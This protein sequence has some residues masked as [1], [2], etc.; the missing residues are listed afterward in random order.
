MFSIELP[1]HKLG[2]LVV[3]EIIAPKGLKDPH[4]STLKSS[5]KLAV[6]IFGAITFTPSYDM[7]GLTPPVRGLR[8]Y[9]DV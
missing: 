6:L 3:S 2:D 8:I 7:K 4:T 1:S 5:E 9:D